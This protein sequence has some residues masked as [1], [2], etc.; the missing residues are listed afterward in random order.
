[1][2]QYDI[3]L[4]H[5]ESERLG[6]KWTENMMGVQEEMCIPACALADDMLMV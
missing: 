6:Y 5:V 3:F 4:K 1:M 2:L